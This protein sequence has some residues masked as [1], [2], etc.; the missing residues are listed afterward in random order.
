[1]ARTTDEHVNDGTALKDREVLVDTNTYDLRKSHF[2][3]N[4]KHS[5]K[6]RGNVKK[7][8]NRFKLDYS[9]VFQDTG[10]ITMRYL[11]IE[12]PSTRSVLEFEEGCLVNYFT[13]LQFPPGQDDNWDVFEENWEEFIERVGYFEYEPHYRNHG[14]FTF[15]VDE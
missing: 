5:Y 13:H 11:F 7:M 6:L 3:I 14:A 4:N 8:D 12:N 10:F 15:Y 2:Y 1:M 9:L